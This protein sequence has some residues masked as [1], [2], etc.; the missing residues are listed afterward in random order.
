MLMS[1]QNTNALYDDSDLKCNMQIFAIALT[2]PT[3]PL[4]NLSKNEY[5]LRKFMFIFKVV[6]STKGVL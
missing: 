1:L 2:I 3:D 5:I 6:I 4:I